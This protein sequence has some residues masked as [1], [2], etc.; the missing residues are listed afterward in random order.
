[1]PVNEI[2]DSLSQLFGEHHRRILTA[3]YRITG[4]MAD[5]EDVT[6]SIFLRLTKS[7]APPMANAASYLYRAAINASLDLLRQ[8]KA[9]PAEALEEA[10]GAIW[11]GRSPE[12]EALGR[13]A[14][15]SLRL[16][17]SEL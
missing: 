6:Q 13:Q 7:S 10:D 12:A 1:M 8:R 14:G 17:I 9:A 5:A 16:A 4:S 2:S 3:S 15:A 11:N